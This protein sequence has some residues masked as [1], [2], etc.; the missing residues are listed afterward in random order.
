[1]ATK[2]TNKN[3]TWGYPFGADGVVL[4]AEACEQLQISDDTLMRYAAKGLLRLGRHAG[5]KRRG[6]V[7]VCKRSIE[8]YLK[9]TELQLS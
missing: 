4:L 7:T 6:K 5:N 9:S 3:D 1:M 2:T 8:I